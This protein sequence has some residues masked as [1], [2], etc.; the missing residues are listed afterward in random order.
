V[1]FL[2]NKKTVFLLLLL[3]VL[4]GCTPMIIHQLDERFG[5]PDT[6]RYNNPTPPQKGA[7]EYWHDVRPLLEQR[8]TVCHGCYDA[9]CQQNLTSWD[10]IARGSNAELVYTNRLHA[11]EPMRLFVDAQTPEE[12][13]KKKFNP[14]L[15]E[16]DD[17]REANLQGSVLYRILDLKRKNPL[18]KQNILNPD[19]FTFSLDRKQTCPVIEK[20]DAF[21][22]DHADWGM[23]YG[24]P[25]LSDKEFST[26]EEWLA[27]GSPVA[28]MPAL[29]ANVQQQLAVWETFFNG[30]SLKQQ[31]VSRYIY[32][33]L[34]LSHL[35]FDEA[36]SKNNRYFFRLVRSSTPPG[37]PIVEIATR[38]PYDDPGSDKF[39]YRIRFDLGSVVEKT[40]MPYALNAARMEKWNAWFINADYKVDALPSYAPDVAGNPFVAFYAL[41][42]ESRYK[43]L[44][45]EAQFIVDTF[46]K[47]P[48]CRGQVALSVIEDNFW[49]FFVSP[50]KM[51]AQATNDFLLKE[52]KNLRL[53]GEDQ[54]N[55]SVFDWLKYSKLQKSYLKA[56]AQQME[57]IFGAADPVTT[58]IVWDGTGEQGNND[59]AA[60]TIFR[61]S[62]SASVVKGLIGPPPETA[63]LVS[64]PL[65]ERIYYLLVAGF[66]VYGSVGH[67]LNT[68]LYMDFLRME[69]ESNFIALLPLKSRKSTVDF[70]YR[71]ASNN[72]KEYVFGD[73]FDYALETGIIYHTDKPQQELYSL[74]TDR[75]G[76]NVSLQFSLQQVQDK[77][78]QQQIMRLQK[79]HGAGIANFPENSVLRVDDTNGK[80]YYFTL[81]HNNSYSNISQLLDNAERRRPA[82]DTLT[83]VP[84]II[85]AYPNAFFKTTT[86]SLGAFIDQVSS[87]KNDADYTALANSFAIR[88]TNPE[89]WA[90]SDALQ[91]YYVQKEPVTGAILDYNRFE[92][93]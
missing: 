16:R 60:L 40:H 76:K 77:K 2:H 11:V 52:S 34:Y 87:M 61:H 50:D 57:K 26:M 86:V 5:T 51:P 17:N 8:C 27:A 9:P 38:R 36:L 80:S 14:I 30:A 71:G 58:D 75:V 67:Q 1:K 65:L 78:I 53:P 24:L 10:G 91:R 46:I 43:F 81:I 93:R 88:R 82:E 73:H 59:N 29:P 68:R 35:Y 79:V 23:P 84:G 48:V 74:L 62:D 66:D 15:N 72:V 18:P 44:L 25:A 70:W 13:R 33:H 31:L 28:K 12:W 32:E 7:P 47:G 42:I 6:A 69:G 45:D 90:F 37:E 19:V 85:G 39:W 21:E 20:M 4:I 3:A 55:A 54:S 92:N 56:K 41:P 63:W 83:V 22:K 64:Y 49:V 89:F